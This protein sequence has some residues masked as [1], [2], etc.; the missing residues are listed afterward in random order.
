MP[1]IG[2]LGDVMMGRAVGERLASVPAADLWS[3]ALREL[4]ARCDAVICNLEC[5]ISER[6]R[7]T[8][9]IPGKPFF[10]RAPPQAVEALTAACVSA[11]GLANNHALD[12]GPE[13]LLD[14]LD[15]LR[16]AGIVTAGAGRDV[17]EARAGVVIEVAGVR[18]G[19]LALTDH[20]AEYA[21]EASSPGV[22]YAEL[23][24]GLPGWAADELERLRERAELVLAFPHWG[25]NM[26]LRPADWQ[27]K[28]ARELLEAGA[29]VVAGHSA[30]VFHGVERR[31]D[32]TVLYDLGDALDDYRVDPQL[33][34]DLGLLALWRPGAS[35]ELELVG[36]A[37]D[38][39]HTREAEGAEAGWIESRLERASRELRD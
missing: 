8:T 12:Y 4:L 19:L 34:N 29:D 3:A 11:A 15:L 13:A 1:T 22:A 7:R 36:L 17:T 27:R 28:R 6:G 33:R 18:L 32:G 10:F 39:C 2:L 35:P 16:A 14:T 38:F 37:L 26:S 30:H 5:C 23:R 21:A 24:R 20:P 31:A 25:P 9:L